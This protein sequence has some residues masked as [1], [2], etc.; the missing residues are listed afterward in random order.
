MG[1]EIYEGT[2][3]GLAIV[4]RAMQRMGGTFG[5][6]SNLGDGS[7]FWM[8]LPGAEEEFE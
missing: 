6:E 1:T 2:G 3:I 4:A 5:V 7:R 8:E